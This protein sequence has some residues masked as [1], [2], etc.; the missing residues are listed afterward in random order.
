MITGGLS[1]L[2]SGH[3][4]EGAAAVVLAGVSAHWGV[5]LLNRLRLAKP[6]DSMAQGLPG[7]GLALLLLVVFMLPVVPFQER[8]LSVAAIISGL[9]GEFSALTV[10]LVITSYLPLSSQIKSARLYLPLSLVGFLLYLSVLTYTGP[11]LYRWGFAHSQLAP[12]EHWAMPALLALWVWVLPLRVA[13]LVVLASVAWLLGLQGS[14]NYW[15]YLLD[16]PLYL[17]ALGLSLKWLWKRLSK[18]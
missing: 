7:L 18:A 13:I 4:P 17:H 3:W 10:L 1:S 6:A 16:L 2:I 11:D 14:R 5:R 8:R 15:D 12:G 9:L